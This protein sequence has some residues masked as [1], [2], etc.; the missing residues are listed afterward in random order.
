MKK[1]LLIICIGIFLVVVATLNSYYLTYLYSFDEIWNYGFASNIVDGLIPY[2]DYNM[3]VGPVFP[4]LLSI[5]ISIFGKSLLVYHIILAI[6]TVVITYLAFR[7]INFYS[8]LI[9]IAMLICS[10]NGY[11]VSTL[12]WLFVLLILLDKEDNKYNDIII[13]III[14]IMALTKQTLA[15]LII[16]SLIYSKNKKKTLAVYFSCLLILLGY[17]II[18]D[19]LFQ[20]FDYCLFG[21]IDFAGNNRVVTPIYLI[22]EII[23]IIL[24]SASLIKSK[25]KNK[26]IFYILLYQIMTFPIMEIYHFVFGW[27]A[28]IYIL[29][30]SKK[31]TNNIKNLLFI[32]LIAAEIYILFTTNILFAIRDRK[33]YEY[34]PNDTFLKGRLITNITKNYIE[35]IDSYIETYSDYKIYILTGHSYLIKLSLD[36]PI[37]KFDLINNGNMGY[38]GANKYLEEIKEDCSKEK[39]LFIINDNELKNEESYNQTNKDILKYVVSNNMKIYT[40]NIFLIYINTNDWRRVNE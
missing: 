36:I 34:Y 12:L 3:I 26:E 11:N 38:N 14:S 29:F 8:I 13:P 31:L 18:N 37:N 21:M 4:Y 19:N 40:S 22:L 20:F 24:L 23:M 32:F 27:S 33:Y 2:K 15:I 7:K 10:I 5:I 6:M 39:C 9:Y 25:F 17:L 16:P 28:F 30:K 1:K 35:T